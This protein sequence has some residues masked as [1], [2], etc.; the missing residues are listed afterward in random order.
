MLN[1]ILAAVCLIGMA[2]FYIDL[3][4]DKWEWKDDQRENFIAG[5]AVGAVLFAWQAT[6][7]PILIRSAVAC[8]ALFTLGVITLNW[9]QRCVKWHA[10]MGKSEKRQKQVVCIIAAFVLISMIRQI[11]RYKG[12]MF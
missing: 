5:G 2:C 12:M 1:T 6:W 4:I 11:M 3:K 10:I 7:H 8:G 9:Y